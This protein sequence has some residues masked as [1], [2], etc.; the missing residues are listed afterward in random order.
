MSAATGPRV[1]GLDPGLRLTGY[2]LVGGEA[3]R[4]RLEEA[5]V[6]RLVPGSG[7]TGAL[8]P[9]AD[10]L[11]ELYRDVSGLIERLGPGSIAVE[12]LFVNPKFPKSAVAVAHARGVILLAARGSGRPIVELAPRLVKHAM[13]G[14]G[15]ASKEQMGLAVQR[16]LG[17][18]EVPSPP[19]VADAI[20]IAIAGLARC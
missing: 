4:P 3:Y 13:T 7:G 15:R 16:V 19:D 14:S 5:G 18:S 9:I 8:P 17:L 10:R 20:A 2:A 6:I 1:L 12:S 11:E